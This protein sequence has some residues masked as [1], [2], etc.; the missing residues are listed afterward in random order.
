[1]PMFPTL[2]ADQQVRVAQEIMRCLRV[3]VA[4]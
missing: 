2:R 4:R 3:E 1:L